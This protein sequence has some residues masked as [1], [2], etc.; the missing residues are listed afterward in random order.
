[1]SPRFKFDREITRIV[2]QERGVIFDQAPLVRTAVR[3]V[4]K[5]MAEKEQRWLARDEVRILLERLH[6]SGGFEYS[7]FRH[8]PS[9]GVLADDRF[10]TNAGRVDG[11]RF[12]YDPICL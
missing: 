7:L 9:E 1:M 2:K 8:L 3:E 12:A 10:W 4:A 11:V 5:A 6:S